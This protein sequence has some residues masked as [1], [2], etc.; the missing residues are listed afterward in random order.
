M[1]CFPM[2]TNQ[3]RNPTMKSFSATV[4]PAPASPRNVPSWPGGPKHHQQD[5]T[6]RKDL[7]RHARDR[8]QGVDLAAI[9]RQPLHQGFHPGADGDSEQ[10]D[11]QDDGDSEQRPMQNVRAG[12]RPPGQSIGRRR[13][14]VVS[15]SR[16]ACRTPKEFSDSALAAAFSSA[17]G[18]IVLA[19]VS[20]GYVRTRCWR[21]SLP[22]E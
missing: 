9:H 22:F 10:R 2:S 20:R 3:P 21:F 12:A 19:L 11:R 5:Q 8:S 6:E 13:R 18:C 17:I 15:S 4:R 7:Q 16:C 1:P 14:K